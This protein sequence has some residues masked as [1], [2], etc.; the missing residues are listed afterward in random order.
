MGIDLRSKSKHL[1]MTYGSFGV[2]RRMIAANLDLEYSKIYD[3]IYNAVI[4][5]KAPE[6]YL[7]ICKNA[8]KLTEEYL[9]THNDTETVRMV[10]FLRM[11]DCRGELRKRDCRRVLKHLNECFEKGTEKDRQILK[12]IGC[13]DKLIELLTDASECGGMKW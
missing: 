6:E 13:Y 9:K 3:M 4:D 7:A 10:A 5:Y 2:I 12:T 1:S 11:S 8:D